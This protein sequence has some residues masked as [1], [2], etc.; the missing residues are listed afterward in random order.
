MRWSD[1]SVTVRRKRL[2]EGVK[3]KWLTSIKEIVG[4]ALTVEAMELDGEG[5]PRTLGAGRRG[6]RARAPV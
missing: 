4:P 1:I 2:E 5:R 6:P 3:I